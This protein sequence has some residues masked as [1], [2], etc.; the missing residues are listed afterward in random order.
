MR[1]RNSGE[2]TG[3]QPIREKECLVERR[4]E[5]YLVWVLVEASDMEGLAVVPTLLTDLF[6]RLVIKFTRS[7]CL[8]VVI[9]YNK[10][11]KL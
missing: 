9:A 8:P 11:I 3:S 7:S 10:T 5:G 1:P 6:S 2:F 4:L